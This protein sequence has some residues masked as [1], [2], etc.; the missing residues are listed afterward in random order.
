MELIFLFA[1]DLL[2]AVL[3]WLAWWSSCP[4]SGATPPKSIEFRVD[5]KFFRI[6]QRSWT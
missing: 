4:A 6:L 2:L 5:G 3:V 1:L